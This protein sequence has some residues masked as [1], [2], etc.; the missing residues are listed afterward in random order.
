VSCIVIVS[1][2]RGTIVSTVS[3]HVLTVA[4]KPVRWKITRHYSLCGAV[5][6]CGEHR[7][8][9]SYSSMSWEWR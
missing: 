4:M 1:Y 8:E 5:V 6:F 9:L 3:C 7:C 2:G